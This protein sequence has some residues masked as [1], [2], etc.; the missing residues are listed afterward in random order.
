MPGVVDEAEA[1]RISKAI[2]DKLKEER[3]LIKKRQGAR[4]DVKVMLL[5]QAESGKSTLQKQFQLY[6][7]SQTLDRERPSWRPIVFFNVIKAVR[8]I[9][10]ELDWEFSNQ[11]DQSFSSLVNLGPNWPDEIGRIRNKLLPLITIE[12]NLASELSNGV[13][14]SGGRSG[15]YVRAGWQALVTPTRS[16][17]LSDIRNSMTSAKTGVMANMAARQL[18]ETQADVERL[19]QHPAVKALLRLRKLRLEESAAFFLEEIHRLSE[20]DYLPSTD[21]ILHVRL[22]TLGVTEHTFDI[23]FA[24]GRYNWLLYDV[25]G[26]RGQRHAWVPYFDDATAV[27]FLAPISAFDQYLEEDPRT[28]RIDDSL[29]LFTAI[30]S[31]KLLKNSS[32]V[33]MLNKTDLLKKKLQAG[34]QVKKYITSYGD[35]PN[36]YDDV[37]E[38]FRAHF[39]QVHKRKGQ[40]RQKLFVHFT[41]MLDVSATQKIIVDVNEAIIRSYLGQSG[42]A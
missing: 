18:A 31:N 15:V 8:T 10:E 42:L 2:D 6:Y 40:S 12:D 9:L 5:G 41:S 32:L 39:S 22:Q 7:A 3:E 20:P 21:D 27:I 1:R 19:W 28:N 4:K 24:G 35:R 26:A 14:V 17:P 16:W 23:D 30:C 37:A 11:A 34:T 33:L 38:Y 29:Q 36:K 13:T 25:G